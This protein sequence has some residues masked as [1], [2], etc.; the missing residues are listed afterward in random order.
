MIRLENNPFFF[1]LN[2]TNSLVSKGLEKVD[3]TIKVWLRTLDESFS[4]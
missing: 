3:L 4:Q 2:K 1:V